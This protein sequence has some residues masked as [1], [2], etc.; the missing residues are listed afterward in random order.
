[1]F[2]VVCAGVRICSGPSQQTERREETRGQRRSPIAAAESSYREQAAHGPVLKL[3]VTRQYQRSQHFRS[4]Q[5]RKLQ[6]VMIA[7]CF[8]K[9]WD[10]INKGYL[11]NQDNVIIAKSQCTGVHARAINHSKGGAAKKIP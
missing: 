5:H 1:M 2:S 3:P 4:S 9:D 7:T 8:N 11:A 10:E 6:H